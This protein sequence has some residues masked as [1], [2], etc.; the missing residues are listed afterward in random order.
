MKEIYPEKSVGGMNLLNR[1]LFIGCRTS[2]AI[3]TS[4]FTL[5]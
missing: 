5:H 1:S 2:G 4:T 3:C